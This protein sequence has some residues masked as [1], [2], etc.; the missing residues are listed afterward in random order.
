[1]VQSIDMRPL[2][3]YFWHVKKVIALFLLFTFSLSQLGLAVEL[4][5]CKG[6]VTDVSLF[7]QASCVCK[8]EANHENED[9]TCHT[10]CHEEVQDRHCD[11]DD[12]AEK[13]DCCKTKTVFLTS[14]KLKA[15]SVAG[16]VKINLVAI[17][18][19]TFYKLQ[20]CCETSSALQKKYPPLRLAE[21][22]LLKTRILRI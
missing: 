20:E 10:P 7:G 8:V 22:R 2:F 21:N 6:D 13:S 16:A 9:Q 4:H 11:D 12:R 1:M 3:T 5:Y 14:A 17:S 18:E 15:H 19:N